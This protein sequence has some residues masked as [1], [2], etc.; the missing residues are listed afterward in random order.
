M[1]LTKAEKQ[2]RYRQRRDADPERRASYLATKRAKYA[3]D[4]SAGFRKSVSEL[5]DWAQ[6]TARKEWKNA[7][8]R[9]R[10]RK[11]T[12]ELLVTPPNSPADPD[13]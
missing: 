7:Q 4:K 5:S 13:G 10:E 6:R 8:R 9:C 12:A 1:A 2:R 3:A 11:R